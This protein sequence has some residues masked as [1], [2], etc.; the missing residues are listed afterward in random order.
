MSR[1]RLAR[2]IQDMHSALGEQKTEIRRFQ[3]TVR[4]LA[5]SVDRL[6]EGW[7]RY[8][9]T[10]QRIDVSRLTRRARRLARIMDV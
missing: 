4:T 6:R 8:D 9:T 10:V 3:E 1:N 7:Q 2:A 5:D